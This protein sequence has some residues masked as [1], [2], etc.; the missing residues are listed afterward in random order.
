MTHAARFAI[1]DDREGYAAWRD[2]TA[3]PKFGNSVDL[4]GNHPSVVAVEMTL[5]QGA[6]F[7]LNPEGVLRALYQDLCRFAHGH[8]G[9]TNADIWES[10][11]PVF[12]PEGF[13]QCWRGFRDT[14]LACTM[15]LKL[16]YPDLLRPEDL[17]KVA[18]YA[19]TPW[20]GLAPGAVN[21]FFPSG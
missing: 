9:H 10:N 17:P 11:G 6:L 16:A 5:S 20:H 7:G 13:T 19:G 18:D 12:V 4:I 1:R 2:G 14:F 8:P 3:D 15:L 21:A